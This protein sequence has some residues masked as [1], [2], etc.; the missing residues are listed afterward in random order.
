[1]SKTG[2][3][4]YEPS[5]KDRNRVRLMIV[6]GFTGKQIAETLGISRTTLYGHYKKELET[7]ARDANSAVVSNL[8][9][10][11]KTNPAAAIF[12]CKTRLGWREVTHL[13]HSGELTINV[14]LIEKT[15]P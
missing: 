6:A 12:W 10:M 13:E 3:P 5:D 4:A 8:F 7:A 11:T 1:M 2:R 14:T 9:S 15:K